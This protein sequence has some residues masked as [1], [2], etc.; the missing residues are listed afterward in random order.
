MIY[1]VRL[2]PKI[3]ERYAFESYAPKDLCVDIWPY[4]ER[5]GIEHISV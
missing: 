4:W 3:S 1:A 2:M 5:S